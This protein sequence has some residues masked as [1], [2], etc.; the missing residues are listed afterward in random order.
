MGKGSNRRQGEDTVKFDDNFDNI[1]FPKPKRVQ[2]K[3]YL[4][5]MRLHLCLVERNFICTGQTV[6]HHISTGGMGTKCSDYETAP[7]CHEHHREIHDK[8]KKI[9]Q[10]KYEVD[11]KE[12][13]E[14][15]KEVWDAK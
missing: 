7:L 6:A 4:E 10:A 15:L 11:L 9:F 1:S 2:D 3:K 5:W 12:E 8:G 14:R 13:A